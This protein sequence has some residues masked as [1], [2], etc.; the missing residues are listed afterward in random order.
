[1]DMGIKVEDAAKYMDDLRVFLF[2]LREGWRWIG[3]ELC[4]TEDWE[5]EHLTSGSSALERTCEL[6]RQSLNLIYP[7]LNF[8]I[9]S[10]EDFPDRR[11][12]TLDFK[13]W[14]R[15]DNVVLFTFFEKPTSSNQMLHRNTALSENTKMATLNA[16]VVRR[17]LNVS[18]ELPIEERV[19]V[20]DR[21]A[22]KLTNSGYNK[23]EIR[24]GIVGALTGYERRLTASKKSKEEKGYIP[25][26]EG[27]EVSHGARMRKKLTGK[28]SWFKEKSSYNEEESGPGTNKNDE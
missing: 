21:V 15:E 27:A 11:L 14:V 7:F 6:I 10:E 24:K 19:Q 16:E 4:W 9:E 12:P 28:S 20:L 22:Q 3:S 25:L 17:M 8:T 1:M 23:N 26:H 2:P 5:R 18:E 13:L